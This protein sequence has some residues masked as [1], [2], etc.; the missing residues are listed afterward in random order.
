MVKNCKNN[1]NVPHDEIM[2]RDCKPLFICCSP[3]LSDPSLPPHG[4]YQL[5]VNG[6]ESIP[7]NSTDHFT[8]T[9][10]DCSTP[11][12]ETQINGRIVK[13]NP[14]EITLADLRYTN[15]NC[16]LGVSHVNIPRIRFVDG[17]SHYELRENRIEFTAHFDAVTGMINI[18]PPIL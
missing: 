15:L 11:P 9:T 13:I 3:D 1:N 10:N 7:I 4:S 12:H 18:H 5:I 14:L 6:S 8:S 2:N 16:T 17:I